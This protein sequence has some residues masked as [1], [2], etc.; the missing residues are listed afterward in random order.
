VVFYNLGTQNNTPLAKLARPFL[1]LRKTGKGA[2][3]Q[4]TKNGWIVMGVSL[5]YHPLR[6][7][8]LV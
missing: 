4:P 6:V 3:K 2:A 1:A 5:W 8:L 7:A